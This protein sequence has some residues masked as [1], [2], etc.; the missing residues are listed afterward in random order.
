MN[1]VFLTG[2]L[3]KDP[4]L[5]TFQNGS[6]QVASFTLAVQRKKDGKADS[7]DADFISIKC[8]GKLAENVFKYV[9]KGRLVGIGGRIQTG[10][11]EKDGKKIYTTEIIARTIEFLGKNPQAE[12]QEAVPSE[13][14][15]K[16]ETTNAPAPETPPED[17]TQLTDDD[18]PF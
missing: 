6:L 9:H 5:K 16:T 17:L 12:S 14:S 3:T 4:E 11:Y 7:P 8:F 15:E 10:S 13:A 1:N 18:I 2:R